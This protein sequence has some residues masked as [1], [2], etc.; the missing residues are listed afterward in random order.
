MGQ[1]E[2]IAH[3]RRWQADPVAFVR[4][5]FNVDP[6]EWQ[7]D[8]LRSVIENPRT[9]MSAC[10]GP[11]KSAVLAWI[12][13]WFLGT[14]V[15]A[16]SMCVSIT[17]KNLKD[18]L[19]K[20]LA[21]WHAK[22]QYLTKLFDIAGERIVSRARSATWWSSARAFPA[23]ADVAQQA[24]TLAGFHG[25]HVLIILDEMGDYPDGVVVAAEGIFANE[26][27][28][29]AKIAAAWNPTR[30]DGPAYRVCTKDR[31]RWNIINITGDP[32][33]RKRSTRISVK[34]AREMI[35][36]WGYDSDI[37]KVNVRGLFPSAGVNTLIS[38]DDVLGAQG[39]DAPATTFMHDSVVWG[40]DPARYG[41]DAS[42]LAR[43]QGILCRKLIQWRDLNGPQ[44]A[45]K[46]AEAIL[47]SEQHGQR[48][49]AIFWDV[50]GIGSSGFDHIQLLGYG[51]LV[52]PVDFGGSP[53]EVKF[54]DKRAEMWWLMAQWLKYKPSLLPTDPGIIG[55]LT[56][57]KMKFGIRQRRTCLILESKEDMRKRGV[58]SPNKGDALCLT[59]AE[60]VARV[61]AQIE[62]ARLGQGH[63]KAEYDPHSVV[64][65]AGTQ[66][67]A[68]TNYDPL[69]LR[70]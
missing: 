68:L 61:S 64:T 56:G 24:Y 58:P 37:V 12:N 23:Q 34:W 7:A 9:G 19:W 36:D 10:K 31:R 70:Q 26:D 8:A 2:A 42:A 46:I 60:P 39:R 17:A 69:T 62:Q 65:V 20:E 59:F 28:D 43:R 51:H 63:A 27:V 57:P 4:E 29:E 32:D 30:T 11:G 48:P 40:V 35:E 54:A 38:A 33:A 3:M 66:P 15:D 50:G 25:R 18:N 16:Q 22:S 5:H 47:E 6:D 52:R 41:D 44:L 21:V 13:W 49:D 53:N 67:S 55:E 1:A 14:R 45:T